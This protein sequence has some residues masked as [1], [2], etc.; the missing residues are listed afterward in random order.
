MNIAI[1][2]LIFLFT[3]VFIILGVQFQRGRWLRLLSG[4]TFG[5]LSKEKAISVGRK[6]SRLMY[7]SAGFCLFMWWWITFSENQV[8]FWFGIGVALIA[9]GF[10]LIKAL[11]EWIRTGY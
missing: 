11:K 10:T 7:F 1:T 8:L 4:N 9:G 6:T 2:I 3:L 5:D